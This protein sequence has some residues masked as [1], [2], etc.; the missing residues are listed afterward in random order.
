MSDSE[1][2]SSREDCLTL[3]FLSSLARKYEKKYRASKDQLRKSQEHIDRLTEVLSNRT[4][5]SFD[6]LLH[7]RYV[8]FAASLRDMKLEAG[9]EDEHFNWLASDQ[10]LD[11]LSF[12]KSN[13]HTKPATTQTD[14]DD[15]TSCL[16]AKLADLERTVDS[17]R[18]HI[19]RLA[20]ENQLLKEA[21]AKHFK[22]KESETKISS[23]PSKPDELCRCRF[24]SR[25]LESPVKLDEQEINNRLCSDHLVRIGP[26]NCELLTVE[27][28]YSGETRDGSAWGNGVL[29]YNNGDRY[30]GQFLGNL[31]HG[32][33]QLLKANGVRFT[34]DFVRGKLHG[35]GRVE[36]PS[37][38]LFHG[39][40]GELQSRRA[41]ELSRSSLEG[42]EG[43]FRGGKKHGWGRLVFRNRDI[44]QGQFRDDEIAGWGSLLHSDGEMYVGEFAN[45]VRAG[46]GLAISKTRE[47]IMSGR[48]VDNRMHGVMDRY[49]V[50]KSMTFLEGAHLFSIKLPPDDSN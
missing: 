37:P 48:F 39:P 28:E 4:Q 7:H 13:R 23:V 49:S 31:P 16:R 40:L 17:Q 2:S 8:P 44:Y 29:K 41:A 33:G 15:P 5:V 22:E 20:F 36:Y 6:Q 26:N 1:V 12:N 38:A 46:R 18:L 42:F 30:E 50:T 43:T 32:H 3:K 9:A 47:I 27:G 45:G 21:A 35:W 34:G 24:N 19:E 14:S 25:V 10:S 11:F